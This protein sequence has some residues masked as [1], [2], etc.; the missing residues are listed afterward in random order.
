[1]NIGAHGRSAV[2]AGR[3]LRVTKSAG[4]TSFA[5][6]HV[7][8][9]SRCDA[10][11]SRLRPGHGGSGAP[12]SIRKA[13]PAA[14]HA[15]DDA[16]DD[17]ADGWPRRPSAVSGR[18]T[19]ASTVGFR[20]P[21]S[22]SA[23]SSSPRPQ[24]GSASIFEST[25]PTRRVAQSWWAMRT[26]TSCTSVIVPE[27]PRCPTGLS[28]AASSRVT[29]IVTRGCQ[30]SGEVAPGTHASYVDASLEERSRHSA[31]LPGERSAAAAE[32]VGHP[33]GSDKP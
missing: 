8:S 5:R 30:L 1:V 32:N 24:R 21:E 20:L 7:H 12:C 25:S 10:V 2:S 22:G 18:A 9:L 28:P 15:A 26:A 27:G 3:R 19:S 16:A 23:P 13:A 31:D 11:L 4:R 6:S 17:A 14:A 33:R 29:W